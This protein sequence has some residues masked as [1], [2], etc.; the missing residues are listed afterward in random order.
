MN[1]GEEL[2]IF[3]GYLM[4]WDT[5]FLTKFTLSCTSDSLGGCLEIGTGFTGDPKRVRAA[6]IGPHSCRIM[7]AA[8]L[9]GRKNGGKKLTRKRDLL[10]CTLLQE[11]A[12]LGVKQKNREGAVEQSQIDVF[13][14]MA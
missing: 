10:V 12:L 8:A 5:Q 6:S 13:H 11:Q 3:R 14:Q 1:P 2:E 4:P 7:L 9:T